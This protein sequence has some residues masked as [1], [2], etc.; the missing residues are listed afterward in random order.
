MWN[1]FPGL[2]LIIMLFI[3]VFP[4][5]PMGAC[6]FFKVVFSLWETIFFSLSLTVFG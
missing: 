4:D 3:C 6:G 2:L 1:A 5:W